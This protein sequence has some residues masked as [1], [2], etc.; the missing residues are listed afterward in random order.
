MKTQTAIP[1]IYTGTSTE[2]NEVEIWRDVRDF[3]GYYKVSN[4]GRIK[5]L[6]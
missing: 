4:L 5:S 1:V 2:K 6:N 3:E